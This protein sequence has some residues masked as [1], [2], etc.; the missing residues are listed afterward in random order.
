MEGSPYREV[1]LEIEHIKVIRKRAKTNLRFCRDC[2]RT[3]DFI[4]VASASELFSTTPSELFEFS[5]SCVCHFLVENEQDIL[6]CLKDLL[7]AMSKTMKTGKVKL[8]EE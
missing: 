3:T 7:T 4:S 2:N 1:V 5:Q 6:L 8:L